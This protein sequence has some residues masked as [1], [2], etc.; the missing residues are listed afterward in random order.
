MLLATEM[1]IPI[2]CQFLLSLAHE[3]VQSSLDVGKTLANMRH[4][5][6]IETLCQELCAASVCHITVSRVMLEEVG[7]GL[8]G[9]SQRLIPLDILL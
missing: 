1:H 7:F 3:C 4:Q 8:Q 6:R 9:F 5:C 2:A